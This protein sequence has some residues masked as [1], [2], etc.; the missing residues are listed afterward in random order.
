[1]TTA[2]SQMLRDTLLLFDA[3]LKPSQA[4]FDSLRKCIAKAEAMDKLAYFEARVKPS[5]DDPEA[6]AGWLS[7][8]VIKEITQR[9]SDHTMTRA[10]PTARAIGYAEALRY[11][12]DHGYLK[13]SQAIGEQKPVAQA[14]PI[15]GN[16]HE[17]WHEL[18]Y[19]NPD[20]LDERFRGDPW[21]I[22]YAG[23][24]EGRAPL[25]AQLKDNHRLFTE[26]RDALAEYRDKHR[27]PI[28]PEARDMA[29]EALERTKS[30]LDA[31][32][33][34]VNDGLVIKKEA[35]FHHNV[36]SAV[37]EADQALSALRGS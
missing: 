15:I 20:R 23:W 2:L 21:R 7:D 13:P 14:N 22:F 6:Q 16:V 26:A 10:Y 30:L 12:R 1:M 4:A 36:R 28:S 29:V 33:A 5:S 9:Y 3:Q 11:A 8:E 19:G 18:G 37:I 32:D 27:S 17:R 34:I 35:A 24:I 25:V 31:V